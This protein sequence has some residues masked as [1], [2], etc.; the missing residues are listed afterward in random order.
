MKYVHAING[1]RVLVLEGQGF[2]ELVQSSSYQKVVFLPIV[3]MAHTHGGNGIILWGPSVLSLGAMFKELGQGPLDLHFKK[4]RNNLSIL[5][6]G[7]GGELPLCL[8]CLL[9]Q[10]YCNSC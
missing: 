8:T 10:G 6:V 9:A 1:T 4:L 3:G 5:L 7:I 2:I